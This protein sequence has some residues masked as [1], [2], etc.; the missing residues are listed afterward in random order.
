MSVGRVG[1]NVGFEKY[2]HVERLF[3]AATEGIDQGEWHAFVKLDGTNGSIWMDPKGEVRCGSR[4]NVLGPGNGNRGFYEWVMA[5]RDKLSLLLSTV[6]RDCTIYGEWLCLSGDTKIKLV[7]G[8]KRGH[9]MTLREMYEYQETPVVERL[10]YVRKDGANSKIDRPSWWKRNGFPQTFSLFIDED[11]IKPQRMAAIIYSG[12]KEV[13]LV[14]T[15]NGYEIKSTLDHRF[16]TNHGWRQLKDIVVG[17]V[18]AT[19]ELKNSPVK[20]N[21][22]KGSRAI[23]A[24]HDTLRR[25]RNCEECGRDNCLEVHHVDENWQNNDP[26]NLKVLCSD[27]HR[28]SHNNITASNQSYKYDFDKV[29]SIE[30][31]GFD[32]CYDLS[33]AA[34]ENSASFIADGFV[35]H[36]CPHTFRGYA[37]HMWNNF[38]VFDVYAND[39]NRY[40]HHNF[41]SH[42]LALHSIKCAP[43]L[44]SNAGKRLD[45]E[46]IKTLLAMEVNGIDSV[47]GVGEG[48]VVKRYDFVNKFGRI[49]WGKFI[50]PEFKQMMQQ[51]EQRV[52]KTGDEAMDKLLT[53]IAEKYITQ[54]LVDK[55]VSKLTHDNGGNWEP[56][57][58]HMMLGTIYYDF[59][60]EELYNA[61]KYFHSPT[62]DFKRMRSFVNVRIKQLRPDLF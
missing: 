60:N 24:L 41:Y 55:T 48:I 30:P 9:T 19:T 44:V 4:N 45:E 31:A 6:F 27:C 37:D 62:I 46:T 33:M 11:K 34:D 26:S 22:G 58:I 5:N 54:A 39:V 20:R 36:N 8:G 50:K 25:N 56:R 7:S 29:V 28:R 15:R 43:V 17:D 59:I 35:V 40:L 32:D 47:H 21:Y 57:L 52:P 10:K 42:H 2:Q 23:H 53:D 1:K 16:W 12:K 13:Y 49:V 38:Y 18:V 3:T 61:L 14:K 51:K